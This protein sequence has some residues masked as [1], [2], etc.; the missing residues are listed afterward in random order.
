MNYI[1][2]LQT[3]RDD[4]QAQIERIAEAANDLMTYAQSTKFQGSSALGTY[5]S[6]NDVIERTRLILNEVNV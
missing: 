6:K 3:D 4:L 5:I 1:K 2:Q